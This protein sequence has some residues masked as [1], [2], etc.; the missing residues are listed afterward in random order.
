MEA[1]RYEQNHKSY[2]IG[3]I[4]LLLCL[5]LFSVTAY[6]MPYLIFNWRYSVPDFILDLR[7]YI[8]TTWDLGLNQASWYVFLIFFVS[9]C[10]S[11]IVAYFL[12]NKIDSE[13]HGIEK[14][15]RIVKRV[16]RRTNKSTASILLRVLVVLCLVFIASQLFE[17]AMFTTPRPIPR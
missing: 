9:S 5:S 7:F 2:V 1:D 17:W 16:R 14:K 3:I 4:S 11:S 8:M 6:I 13:I 12:S 10:I 15:P